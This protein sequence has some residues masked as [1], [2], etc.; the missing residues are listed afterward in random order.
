MGHKTQMLGGEKER[1]G[2][3]LQIALTVFLT[4][5]YMTD[6]GKNS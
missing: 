6:D 5:A 2:F 3:A 4:P 1:K